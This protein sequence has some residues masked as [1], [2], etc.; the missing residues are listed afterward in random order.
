[1]DQKWNKV[2]IELHSKE[3]TTRSQEL[4]QYKDFRQ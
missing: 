3:I 1:M 2:K 4:N